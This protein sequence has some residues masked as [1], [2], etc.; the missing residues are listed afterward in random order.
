M[1][2]YLCAPKPKVGFVVCSLGKKKMKNQSAIRLMLASNFIGNMAQGIT[3]I[4][5]PMYFTQ[6]GLGNEFV[7]FYWLVT[8]V[9]LFWTPYAGMIVDKYNRK[10]IFWTANAACALILTGL[11]AWGYFRGAVSPIAAGAAFAMTFFNYNIYYAC[12]YSFLQEITPPKSY[13][14][15][16]STIEVQGQFAS[17][18]AGALA[19]L[20]WKGGEVWGW[21]IPSLTLNEIIGINAAAYGLTFLLIGRMQYESLATASGENVE[22]SPWA[23]LKTGWRWLTG[24]PYI[25]IFGV[26]SFAVFLVVIVSTFSINPIYAENHLR[27]GKDVYAWSEVTYALGAVFAGGFVRYLFS[28][29]TSIRGI[30]ILTFLTVAQCWLLLLTR[31]EYLFYALCFLL[32]VTNAGVRVLRVSYMFTVVPNWVAGRVN[33]IF[34]VSNVLLRLIFLGIFALPFFHYANNIIYAFGILGIFVL[35]AGLGLVAYYER[36]PNKI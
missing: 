12:F 33:S 10:S 15:I 14:K 36:L 18:I 25:L 2:A 9:T 3:M 8:L 22:D 26:L 23:R 5:I 21:Q 19:A 7:I 35:G 24:E 11:F 28:W 31:S 1:N 29:T 27:A 17:A 34:A 32:G 4:T 6:G 30:I 20:L 16:A 13:G